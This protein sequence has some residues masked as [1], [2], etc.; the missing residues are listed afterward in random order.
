MH[1]IWLCAIKVDCA[2]RVGEQWCNVGRTENRRCIV[3]IAS[4]LKKARLAKWQSTTAAWNGVLTPKSGT[5]SDITPFLCI[6]DLLWTSL[7]VVS[8]GEG[9]KYEL[10]TKIEQT[11][12]IKH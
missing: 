9:I 4:P 2:L 1:L 7:H 5:Y 12:G 6:G 3:C 10:S 11:N 8:T